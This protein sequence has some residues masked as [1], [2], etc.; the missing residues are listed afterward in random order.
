MKKRILKHLV[1]V[2]AIITISLMGTYVGL[3]VYYHNAFAYGTWI[4]GVYCTGR[5]I[6]EVNDELV[7]DFTYEGVH[8]YDKDGNVFTIPAEQISYQFD[9]GRAL[10]I[11]QKQQNAWMWIDS[12][13]HEHITDLT[14][15]VSYDPVKFEAC[16][17]ALPFSVDNIPNE[18][19]RVEIIKTDRGYELVNER[20]EVLNLEEAKAVILAAVED[21][22]EEVSLVEAGCYHDLELTDQMRDTL[23]LWE[24]LEAFQQCGIVYQMGEEQIPLDGSVVSEWIALD[25]A[26][27]F[28]LD[29]AGQLQ[30]KEGAIEEFVAELAAEYDTVGAS[31]Q[32]HATRGEIVTVEGGLYGN[33]IDQKAEIAYLT[34]AFRE[35]RQEVH[36]PAYLQ[37]A[38]KQ[39]KEDIGSTYIEVDMG[40]QKMYYYVDGVLQIETPI[41]TGNTSRRMGTP[42]GVNYVYLKQKNRILRG[43]NYAS[44]VDFWM[45]VK[46]NIGIHDAAWRSKFGGEIFKTDGSHGCVNTP[47]E[48]M[49]QLYDM[50]QVGT[51]VVMFY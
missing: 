35:R 11:Y 27:G 5:S 40:E 31:R 6:Q 16:F 15:V 3:A 32:F 25:E 12:M 42:S 50:A 26:G 34:A 36:E 38:W 30:L 44:H 18:E 9:F 29:E 13:I 10:E 1:I 46:G 41:V 49:E 2:L 45:P 20:T 14:P 4:N 23:V 22:K 8:V 33:Q 19:R 28:L 17:A 43:A 51:P 48:A 47:R 7:K 24:K 39:G 37:E 21:S